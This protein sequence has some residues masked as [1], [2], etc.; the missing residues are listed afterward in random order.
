MMKGSIYRTSLEAEGILY[1]MLFA[2]VMGLG[3][4]IQQTH[5][6]I[7]RACLPA[8][9]HAPLRTI[10]SGEP[11]NHRSSYLVVQPVSAVRFQKARIFPHVPVPFGI[12]HDLA[13]GLGVF[14]AAAVLSAIILPLKPVRMCSWQFQPAQEY[15]L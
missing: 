7:F 11:V 1:L 3:G 10:P 4:W 8:N 5:H 15:A 12:L 9:S 14:Q 6:L 13:C 2:L